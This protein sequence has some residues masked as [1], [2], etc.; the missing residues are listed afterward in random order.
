MSK[1][2]QVLLVEDSPA[3]ITLT[4]E[5]LKDTG[6]QTSLSVVMDGEQAI[7]YLHQR[8]NY[9]QAVRPDVIL[10]DLN[11]PKKNGHEVLAD[12]KDHPELE[13]IPVV[14]LT[15]SQA[16]EDIV[17]ALNLR[18]NYYLSK[19]VH[20]QKLLPILHAIDSLWG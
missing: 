4:E 13:D 2:M 9:S 10:L 7:D 8:G 14:V 3:D 12:M 16:E 20:S 15:V 18:M 19:P 5:A 17:K 1:P 11:M 6:V